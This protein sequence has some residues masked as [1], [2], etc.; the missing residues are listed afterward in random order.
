MGTYQNHRIVF[1]DSAPLQQRIEFDL[2]SPF[3]GVVD[4]SFLW[5]QDQLVPGDSL[6]RQIQQPDTVQGGLLV[7]S[8]RTRLENS[9]HRVSFGISCRRGKPPYL[10]P[11]GGEIRLS[12]FDTTNMGVKLLP[13]SL[14]ADTQEVKQRVQIAERIDHGRTG[15]TPTKV[16]V[17]IA[18]GLGGSSVSISDNVSFI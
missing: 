7:S 1:E 17:E 3:D 15:Q 10:S 2:H 5:R 4:V 8:H 13:I 11:L 16:S 9:L 6:F 14:R 12:L 18:S